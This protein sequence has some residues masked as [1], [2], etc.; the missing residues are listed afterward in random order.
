MGINHAKSPDLIERKTSAESELD[1]A[2]KEHSLRDQII[3]GVKLIAI[4]AGACILLWLV[5]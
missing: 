3:F 2:P 4:G 5:K 1:Y